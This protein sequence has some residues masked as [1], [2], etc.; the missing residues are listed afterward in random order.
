MK[1]DLNANIVHYGPS[2]SSGHYYIFIRYAL[3]EWYKFDDE[4][5]AFVQEVVLVA[6]AYIMFYSKRGTPWFSDYIQ[7]HRHFV[8]FVISKTSLCIPN[9]VSDVGES[10][11]AADESSLKPEL[12]KIDDNDSPVNSSSNSIYS[13]IHVQYIIVV[14]VVEL[15]ILI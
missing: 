8:N 3:N 10:N 13:R 2:I 9:H 1:Y 5:V 6:E 7:I 11:Y 15:S 14:V 4:K 12:N